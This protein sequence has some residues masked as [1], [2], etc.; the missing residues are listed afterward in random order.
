MIAAHLNLLIGGRKPEDESK[1][2]QKEKE[3]LER[4]REWD[5]TG[6]AYA[7]EQATRPGTLG[8]VISSS[9]LALLSW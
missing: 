7:L 9:P 1:I 4:A 8:L 3:G 2:T 6:N 5:K